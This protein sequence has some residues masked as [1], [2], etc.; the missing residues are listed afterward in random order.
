MKMS[1]DHEQAAAKQDGV[2]HSDQVP[3]PPSLISAK[4]LWRMVR[5]A[6]VVIARGLGK[7]QPKLAALGVSL[8][9]MVSSSKRNHHHGAAAQDHESP[10]LMTYLAAALSCRS[11]DPAAAVHPYPSG[12]YSGSG[13]AGLSSLSCRSMDPDAAVYQQYRPREVEFS[14]KS[15]PLHRRHRRAH[16]HRHRDQNL[17]L[18]QQQQL[19][20]LPKHGSTTAV[21]TLYELMDEDEDG[22]METPI[23]WAAS[24]AARRPAPRQVRIT[25]SPFVAREDDQEGSMGVVDRRADEFILWFHDQ[26][27]M[28]QQQQQCPAARDRTTNWVR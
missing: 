1:S 26:L 9:H 24:A 20:D 21:K 10:A 3:S 11:M 28:Q 25:D 27:R 16:R 14:C 5:E 15:T 7:H 8:H 19:G 2:G 6:R 13:A 4:K 22:D 12:S 17:L 18:P 23:P